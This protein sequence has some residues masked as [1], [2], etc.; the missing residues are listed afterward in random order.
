MRTSSKALIFA[1]AGFS[2]LAGCNEQGPERSERVEQVSVALETTQLSDEDAAVL[3][4]KAIEF[5]MAPDTG[6]V[7]DM[8]I[9][10]TTAAYPPAGGALAAAKA[11]MGAMGFFDKSD[12]VADALNLIN[13]RLQLALQRITTLELEVAQIKDHVFQSDNEERIYRL[14]IR[15]GKLSNAVDSLRRR[16]GDPNSKMDLAHDL[17]TLAHEFLPIPSW[18][19]WEWSDLHVWKEPAT[20]QFKSQMLPGEVKSLPILEAYASVLVTWM[21]AIEYAADGDTQWVRQTY[22]D[23][24]RQHAAFLSAGSSTTEDSVGTLADYVKAQNYCYFGSFG[25][26][27][28]TG[29]CYV[30]DVC[31]DGM[32]RRELY[33]G[34]REFPGDASCNPAAVPVRTDFEQSMRDSYGA[35]LMHKLV[36]RLTRLATYGTVKVAPVVKSPT[37]THHI[38]GVAPNGD[39][40]WYEN[41]ITIGDSPCPGEIGDPVLQLP[42]L[43][44]WV[45]TEVSETGDLPTLQLDAM[46]ANRDS[47]TLWT[48]ELSNA[49][50]SLGG[51]F[52]TSQKPAAEHVCLSAA[53]SK[54]IGNGWDIFKQIV[55]AGGNGIYALAPDGRLSWYRHDGS[56]D[57]STRWRGPVP[58]GHGW[59]MY[60]RVFAGSDGVLY[61]IDAAGDLYWYREIDHE[62]PLYFP[63]RL[64][65]EWR[66]RVWLAGGFGDYTHVFA[67]TG[68]VI[69]VVTADGRLLWTRHESLNGPGALAPFKEIGQGWADFKRLFT[70]GD[71]G[72]I[73]AVTQAGDMYWYQHVDWLG[74]SPTW[75]GPRLVTADFSELGEIFAGMNDLAVSSVN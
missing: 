36:D 28:A 39:L 69:Y 25:R 26:D 72:N 56:T 10:A 73:Y 3:I 38:Y 37:Y 67:G 5:G 53:G 70:A 14:K 74:G 62:E 52:I 49:S 22:G 1:F 57:G 34:S 55:P 42:G 43:P 27:A 15:M 46:A 29:E 44:E 7:V 23:E 66:G 71:Q 75:R 47:N 30:N 16:P 50:V 4:Q 68:G 17:Q 60:Q 33:A 63:P 64:T 21:A 11:L 13:Q 54:K 65:P 2:A 61:G 51:R 20:G 8:Y 24:L 45:D 18:H 48:N 31:H 9:T 32:G 6:D 19:D 40:L 58:V 41:A 35:S 12:P 59:D